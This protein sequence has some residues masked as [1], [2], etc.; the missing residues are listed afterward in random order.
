MKENMSL[1]C[2]LTIKETLKD[3]EIRY[4]PCSTY[5][6]IYFS[7]LKEL[8]RTHPY[9][10]KNIAIVLNVFFVR[11]GHSTVEIIYF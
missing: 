3:D 6:S 11:S 5:V 8:K 1:V 4:S 2:Q 7:K 9:C 10:T